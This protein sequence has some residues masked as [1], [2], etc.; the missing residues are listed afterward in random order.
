VVGRRTS[1][2]GPRD[3]GAGVIP[4][5]REF[6]SFH[7]RK[8]RNGPPFFVPLGR[9]WSQR[10]WA[11]VRVSVRDVHEMP[12][13]SF[14]LDTVGFDAFGGEQSDLV[15]DQTLA[16]SSFLCYFLTHQPFLVIEEHPCRKKVLPPSLEIFA[17]VLRNP[18]LL[19]SL[20]ET[21]CFIAFCFPLVNQLCDS[22][23]LRACFCVEGSL[24][25]LECFQRPFVRFVFLIG[26]SQLSS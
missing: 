21:F 9:R 11:C 17:S 16:A 10:K 26:G 4:V 18:Q 12:M 20:A 3:I 23:V 6:Y 22:F 15:G 13:P 19:S 5:R 24:F 7:P 25:S 1:T 8:T 14:V 2:H